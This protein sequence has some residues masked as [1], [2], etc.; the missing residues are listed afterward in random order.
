MQS[1]SSFM[2]S[3]IYMQRTYIALNTVQ[4]I[5]SKAI[6]LAFKE[7]PSIAEIFPFADSRS[8]ISTQFFLQ[9]IDSRIPIE[10]LQLSLRD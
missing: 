3:R 6:R 1:V 10:E 8:R 4:E 2:N 5:V 9:I 7:R